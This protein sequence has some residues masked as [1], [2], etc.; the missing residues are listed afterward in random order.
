MQ[1]A[2]NTRQYKRDLRRLMISVGAGIAGFGLLLLAI[3]AYAGWSANASAV[4]REHQ[5]VAN[6]LNRSITH[7]LDDMKSVAWWDDAV[8]NISEARINYAFVDA[9]MGVFL[10]DT[11][12]HDEVYLLNAAGEP[13]YAFFS[14]HRQAPDVYRA[15]AADLAPL[16]MDMRGQPTRLKQR[17]GVF[18]QGDYRYLAGGGRSARWAG[19]IVS[20]GGRPAIAAAMTIAPNVNMSLA[21]AHPFTLLTI[22]YIDDEFLTSLGQQL[23]LPDLKREP[24]PAQGARVSQPFVTDDGVALGH[25]TWATKRPG[26]V[27]LTVILPLAAFGVLLAGMLSFGMLTRLKRASADLAEREEKTRHQAKHDALSGLPNRSFF[28]ERLDE[29][30]AA[31]AADPTGPRIAVAYIDVDRFKDINDT[32]GHDAGDELV[33]AVG[34]RLRT[35]LRHQDFLARFGGDEFAVLSLQRSAGETQ[36]LSRSI[37]AALVEPFTE[38]G[39]QIR[40]TASVGVAIAPDHGDTCGAL[41]RNADIAL[42]EAKARGRD[43]AVVFNEAMAQSVETRRMIELD[44]RAAVEAK[45]LDFRYRP[46]VAATGGQVVGVETLMQWRHPVCGEI[47]MEELSPIAE[48]LGLMPVIGRHMLDAAFENA[49]RWPG[50]EIAVKLSRTQFR[51]PELPSVLARLAAQHHIAHSRIVLEITEGVLLDSSSRTQDM[52]DTLRQMGFK[53]ALDDFG[54]GYSSLSHLCNFSFDKIKIDRSFVRGAGK[55]EAARAIVQAVVTLGRGLGMDITATGVE[56][57]IDAVTMRL[58]GCT[59]MQGFHF[60]GPVEAARVD[61]MFRAAQPQHAPAEPQAVRVVGE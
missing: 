9:N 22:T 41:M 8:T 46:I 25:L 20:V 30:L 35:H 61:A 56:S 11:Y 23:L 26:Q 37:E 43:C 53:A 17:S 49:A 10:T 60:S 14:D 47:P 52:L 59:E 4:E 36:A 6:A 34:A 1:S 44:L 19:H 40:V 3:I 39:G 2:D 15:R 18:A 5:L 16:L 33:K 58:L 32:L 42:Y 51:D 7:T 31:S 38:R 57:E 48:D 27:L 50:V 29:A 12:A 24:E 28:L 21:R 54:A 55:R 45:A 13:V